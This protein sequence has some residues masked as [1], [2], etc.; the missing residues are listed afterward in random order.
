MVKLPT[1][2]VKGLLQKLSRFRM[3]KYWALGLV[4]VMILLCVLPALG[5]GAPEPVP[6]SAETADTVP[7][8]E[9]PAPPEPA[10]LTEIAGLEMGPEE[11]V[12]GLCRDGDSPAALLLRWDED[13][14]VWR[15]RLAE[16]DPE[17]ASVR[18]VTE[19][20]P[21]GELLNLSR[22]ALSETEICLVDPEQERCA[23][24]DR[25]GRFLGLRDYPVMDPAHL[26]WRNRLLGEDC[27]RKEAGWAQLL[28]GDGGSLSRVVGFY[29]QAD[30]LYAIEEPF[31]E[32]LAADGHR[33]LTLRLEESAGPELA[34]LDPEAGL[35]LDRL[36]L[37]PEGAPEEDW[38][39]LEHALLGADWA[40][41]ALSREERP[42][43]TERG[44][45][46]WYPQAENSGPLETEVFSEQLL[47]DELEQL[48]QGLEA[49][50]LELH[51]DEAPAPELTPVTG[52]ELPENRCQT[53]ASLFGQY[54][55]LRQLTDFAEKLPAGMI[56]EISAP[57][58]GSEGEAQPL[59]LWIVREIP[60]D[61][62]AFANAWTEP[63]MLCFAT[64]EYEPSHLAHEFMHVMDLRLSGWLDSQ[65]RSLE[66]EWL[67]LSPEWAF[68]EGLSQEQND[69][70]AGYFVS[71]Y[72]RSSA[73]EDRAETFQALFDSPEPAAEQ[74]WYRDNPGV[75]AKARWLCQ[76]LRA[77]F[78]SVQAVERAWWEK[79]PPEQ[80]NDN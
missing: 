60:G 63:P 47:I 68:Q 28:R 72:A 80:T 71:W 66:A 70:L 62:A 55:L 75:Q 51:L 18:A 45:C 37:R 15:S 74:W 21:L 65:G 53:G 10:G 36:S 32:I 64:Q 40:L 27:F 12:F 52:L 13:A 54:R 14:Q 58:P 3:N 77:A 11:S 56:R 79:L 43:G 17:T 2:S 7:A 59:Q 61:A 67:A 9:P 24:F 78:P 49:Q 50:G 29:D 35:C 39:N 5:G 38:V 19:L 73:A 8:T 46:F 57:L 34:L 26:G 20:E 33:L 6:A 1:D 44:L 31:D 16:L 23:A 42:E 30:R 41:L 76:M 25:G 69:A 48:R 4:C 22:L